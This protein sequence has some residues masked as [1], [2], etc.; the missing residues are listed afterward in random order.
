MM[1][2]KKGLNPN[3]LKIKHILG[4]QK[5]SVNYP[6]SSDL[7]Y[8]MVEQCNNSERDSYTFSDEVMAKRFNITQERARILLDSLVQDKTL[9]YLKDTNKKR[10]YELKENPLF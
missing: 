6:D 9:S 10:V 4:C 1:M 2:F 3:K 5:E 8:F 7:L